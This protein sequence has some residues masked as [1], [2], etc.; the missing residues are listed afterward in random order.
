[1]LVEGKN[2]IF[3]PLHIVGL[4]FVNSKRRNLIFQFAAISKG[5]EELSI[6]VTVTKPINSRFL[7]P[8]NFFSEGQLLEFIFGLDSMYPLL[9]RE[10]P[11][12]LFLLNKLNC[13]EELLLFHGSVVE[14]IF[15]PSFQMGFKVLE[16]GLE[17]K[18]DPPCRNLLVPLSTDIPFE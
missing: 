3:D 12:F 9:I 7:T 15:I 2:L 17:L 5:V 18:T 16:F 8:H 14:G 6:A 13:L 11:P 10:T 4:N 1:M